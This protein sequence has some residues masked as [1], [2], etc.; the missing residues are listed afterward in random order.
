[1]PASEITTRRATESDRDAMLEIVRQGFESYVD[2][3]P[4]GW[5]PPPMD[6]EREQIAAR[7]ADREG[8]VLLA[9]SEGRPIGHFAFIPAHER[10][11]GD[12]PMAGAKSPRVPG[13]AH[14]WQLFVAPDWWGLGVAGLLHE[15]GTDAMRA[16]DYE[17][18]RLF[19]PSA[20]RR[21]RRFYERHGWTF[22]D[23]APNE[24]L[25]LDV[26]EYRIDL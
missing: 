15:A 12:L 13:L 20:H 9:L 18:A 1:M 21:A 7:L 17:R 3:A 4:P 23:Q 11:A 25:G 16:Q 10:S 8:W 19:T 24:F 6:G 26:A 2:F 22:H 5:R 14:L